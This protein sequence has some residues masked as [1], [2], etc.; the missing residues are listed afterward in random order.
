[1]KSKASR[2]PAISTFCLSCLIVIG[3]SASRTAIDDPSSGV[4]SAERT[5]PENLAYKRSLDRT[6]SRKGPA[7]R[8]SVAAARLRLR[9]EK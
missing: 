4:T 5:S 2:P 7:A 6:K 3:P 8:L 9:S 1:M